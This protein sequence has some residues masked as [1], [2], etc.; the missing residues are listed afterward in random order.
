MN[1][2]LGNFGPVNFGEV[3][4]RRTD[5]QRVMHMSLPCMSTGVLK[6]SMSIFAFKRL[7]CNANGLITSEVY[8]GYWPLSPA[9]SSTN[10][11][12]NFQIKSLFLL[13]TVFRICIMVICVVRLKKLRGYILS[14][15]ICRGAPQI[16]WREDCAMEM[17]NNGWGSL[18]PGR[19]TKTH[20]DFV[21]LEPEHRTK[22]NN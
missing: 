14:R 21:V 9:S 5:R 19:E 6:T 18:Q 4:N 15:A 16:R 12:F 8:H 1:Y 3:T 20:Q 11:D 2:F 22:T 13:I 17:A 10:V 7:L